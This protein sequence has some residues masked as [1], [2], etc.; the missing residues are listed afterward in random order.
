LSSFD[1]IVALDLLKQAGVSLCF[2]TL[3]V[4]G[5]LNLAIYCCFL[6]KIASFSKSGRTNVSYIELFN[7]ILNFQDLQIE[8]GFAQKKVN[9]QAV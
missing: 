9:A 6:A 7:I 8:F 4:T 1:A 2:S 5:I 3:R